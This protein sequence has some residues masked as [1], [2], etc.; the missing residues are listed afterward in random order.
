LS[1]A[2]VAVAVAPRGFADHPR[3]AD[4]TVGCAYDGSPESE[5][6][7]GVAT[8]FAQALDA[9]LRVISVHQRIA[10]GG[11]VS[12]SAVGY[13]SVNDAMRE[14]LHERLAQA[15]S[16]VP[17][18]VHAEARLLDG[19]PAEAL[20]GES[21][22]LDLLVAG[23]RGYGPVRAVLLGSVSRALVRD[24][25]CPVVVSPRLSDQTTTGPDDA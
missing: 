9:R 21:E 12:V 15:T 4:A 10:F 16:A 3:A 24:A 23:S 11:Q 5:V 14:A 20:I 7:L 22:T 25:A 6:A 8:E 13:S 1:G 19:D 2:P 18:G 17:D